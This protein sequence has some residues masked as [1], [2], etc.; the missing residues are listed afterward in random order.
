[1]GRFKDQVVLVT[2][3]GRGIGRA[4]A[5]A[6]GQEGAKVVVNYRMSEV[7][8]IRTVAEIQKAGGEAIAVRADVSNRRDV[9]GMVQEVVRKFGR[10][11]VLVNNAAV[12][13][14]KPLLE[15]SEELWDFVLGTNLKGTFLCSQAAARVMLA[16][17]S[18]VIINIASG[19]GLHPYPGYDTSVP[20]AASKAGVI[21]LTKRMSYELA[22]TVR[23]NCVVPGIIDSKPEEWT[24]E[25]RQRFAAAIPLRRVGLPE[26]V[27]E[28]VLFLAS[29]D[30]EYI[31]GQ[32]LVIDGGIVMR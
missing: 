11:D 5:I 2:G 4:I 6:F 23:V 7:G 17:G 31:T 21:M 28:G 32:T 1:M 12:F 14:S 8:A 10:L 3:G 15:V 29:K 30:A 16:Q 22:P 19:G 20:Y 26:E 27:A 13:T 24:E 9:E 18:G 25:I